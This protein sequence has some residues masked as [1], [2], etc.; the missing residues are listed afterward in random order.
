[1]QCD[2][3]WVFVYDKAKNVRVTAAV[4]AGISDHVWGAEG[5]ARLAD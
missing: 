3:T 5:I 2:E 1:V 4:E